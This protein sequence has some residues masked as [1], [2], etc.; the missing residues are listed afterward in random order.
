MQPRILYLDDEPMNLTVFEAAMPP[1]WHVSTFDS[2]L[3]ALAELEKAA[4]AVV[5]ADQR[6][7]GMTG[8]QF[9]ELVRKLVPDA[10]RIIV[11]G[12]SDEESI[13]DSVRKV[14]VFDY[15]RK[16]WDVEDLVKSLGRAVEHY[17][18]QKEKDA[19]LAELTRSKLELE[20]KHRAMERQT[21][22]LTTSHRREA[23]MR[24]ELEAWVP[25][26]VLWALGDRGIKLP[27]KRDLVGIAFDIVG[28]S[29]LHDVTLRERPLRSMV[30]QAFSEAII[31]HGG[32]RESHAGDSGYGH[33]GLFESGG[34]PFDAALAAAREFRV[35]LRSLAA[36]AG[37]PVECGI[38]LHLSRDS[39]VDVHQ[40]QLMTPRGS[41]TQKSFDTTS[42]DID[43]LHRMEKLVHALPGTSIIMSED[44]VFGLNAPPNAMRD[45]GIHRFQK[46]QKALRLF[47]VPSDLATPQDLEAFA[48]TVA[49]SEDAAPVGPQLAA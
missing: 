4:P 31:R 21:Q 15:V 36:L 13:I 19:L 22:E 3:R 32:W 34:N 40:V 20:E 11:T 2:P 41:V 17:R 39:S 5:V 7:P 14:Q 1:E 45:L 6:M 23:E 46:P 33:F 30:I 38:A 29:S 9:L 10:V 37:H 28:S 47:L 16:P 18:M 49:K 8:V 24:Q 43:I 25:P 12:F 48:E 26:F 44:F 35:A 42:K 27:V